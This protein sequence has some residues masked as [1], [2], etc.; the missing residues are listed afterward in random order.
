LQEPRE[1]FD[2]VHLRDIIHKRFGMSTSRVN[3]RVSASEL[4]GNICEWLEVPPG[5]TGLDAGILGY[6]IAGRPL[7]FQHVFVPP[8]TPPLEIRESQPVIE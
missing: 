3:V 2:G 6:D 8:H 5:T 4:P 7:S 1:Y